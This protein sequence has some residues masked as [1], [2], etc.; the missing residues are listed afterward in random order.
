MNRVATPV[1]LLALAIV[2]GGAGPAIAAEAD[3]PTFTKDVLPILQ[4][5]CQNCHRPGTA[6]PMALLSYEQVRPWA[7]AIKDRV[8]TR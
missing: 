6:A 2:A 1:V 3:T 8:T 4:R 7:R 5:S